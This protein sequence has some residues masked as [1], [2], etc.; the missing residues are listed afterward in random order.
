[1]LAAASRAGKLPGEYLFGSVGMA[2]RW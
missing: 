2:A 1:M